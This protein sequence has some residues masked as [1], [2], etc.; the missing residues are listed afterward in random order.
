MKVLTVFGTRPEAVKL[1]PLIR[2]LEARSDFESVVCVTAQHREMLDQ[3]LDVFRITPDYDLDIMTNGQ[4]LFDITNRAL[5]GLERVLEETAPDV[6]VVQGDTTTTFASSLAAYYLGIPVAHVEAGLRTGNKRDPFPEEMNRRLAD[7]L[8]HLY[9]APTVA[10]EQNLVRE[11]YPRERIFV[12]GNTVV[13]AL[14]LLRTE[15]DDP[16]LSKAV[17]E[18]FASESGVALSGRRI[19]LVTGHRRESFEGGMESLCLGIRKIARHNPDLETVFAVHLNPNVRRPVRQILGG[20]E[21]VHL[22]EPQDYRTFVWL[23]QKS[24]LILTDSG[25]IQ[26]EAPSLGKPVLVARWTTERSEALDAGVAKLVGT[27]CAS[28]FKAAQTLLDDPQEYGRMS[29]TVNPFGDGKSS[30]RIATILLNHF[31][32]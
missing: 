32:R 6:V 16:S 29:K 30:Q 18:Q 15:L 2:E 19:M 8:S 13:D 27:D 5:S 17:E 21:R 26:E 1:A 10:A 4:G 28:I 9:F 25:G 22:V 11:G 7:A 3:M 12:T 14:F 20:E 23:M 31:E 24:Y